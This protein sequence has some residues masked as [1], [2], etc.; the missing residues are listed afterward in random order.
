MRD[1]EKEQRRGGKEGGIPEKLESISMHN[2]L[3]RLHLQ[4]DGG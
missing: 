3:P 4:R 2:I 1:E